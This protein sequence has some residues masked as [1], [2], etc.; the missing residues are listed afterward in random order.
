M[1]SA[2]LASDDA[3]REQNVCC[4]FWRKSCAVVWFHGVSMNL[5]RER[6]VGGRLRMNNGPIVSLQALAT[7]ALASSVACSG[8]SA[9]S[10]AT[11]PSLAHRSG[12][13]GTPCATANSEHASMG[14]MGGR[15]QQQLQL[16]AAATAAKDPGVEDAA[17][18]DVTM[19]NGWRLGP[20]VV[21]ER[22]MWRAR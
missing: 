2:W 18:Q 7:A 11:Q 22:A 14:S 10:V 5:I 8:C 1:L 12:V 21:R 9:G 16:A 20:S 6:A 4:L 15:V 13:V 19:S 17:R 3:R